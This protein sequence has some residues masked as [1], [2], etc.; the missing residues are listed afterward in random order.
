MAHEE[1]RDEELRELESALAS[2][3]PRASGVDRDRLLFLAGQ[4]RSRGDGFEATPRR[5]YRWIWPAISA[6]ST[7]AAVV[8]GVL[9]ALRSE[10]RVVREVV[11]IERPAEAL[12][13]STD[14]QSSPETEPL[15]PS[16]VTAAAEMET[17]PRDQGLPDHNYLEL[18]RRVFEVGL[19]ALPEPS[20]TGGSTDG[21][22]PTRQEM[23]RE[24]LGDAQRD[25]LPNSFFD[26]SLLMG[27]ML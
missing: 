26:W 23:L 13:E 11:Y 17:W 12:A 21:P 22:P 3:R 1:L 5:R 16:S 27:E 4:A 9:L 14:A 8:L 24:F 19:A 25:V 6:V 10:P 2:L 20:S 15:W 7:A 18:R